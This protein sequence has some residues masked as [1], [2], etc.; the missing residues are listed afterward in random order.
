MT[1]VDMTRYLKAYYR[2][3]NTTLLSAVCDHLQGKDGAVLERLARVVVER[4]K[5]MPTVAELRE[6]ER[7]LPMVPALAL[8]EPELTPEE[9]AA[10]AA[11]LAK[12]LK[13]LIEKKLLSAQVK[14][15]AKEN[16]MLKAD[17]GHAAEAAEARALE[18]MNGGTA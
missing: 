3:D 11:L 8:P 18:D 12:L 9:Y 10:G 5:W 14:K 15:L 2:C 7:T 4:C 6:V 1:S 17:L 13:G 16:L